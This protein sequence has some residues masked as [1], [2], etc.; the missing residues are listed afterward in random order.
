MLRTA[1]LLLVVLSLLPA[2]AG[3]SELLSIQRE[4]ELPSPLDTSRTDEVS[5]VH[6]FSRGS[7][8]AYDLT[9]DVGMETPASPFLLRS[10]R[11]QVPFRI[12]VVALTEN[13]HGQVA[14][15]FGQPNIRLPRGVRY[16]EGERLR[17]GFQGL[18]VTRVL[19]PTGE[20]METS[21]SGNPRRIPFSPSQVAADFS[22][23][24]VPALPAEPVR[25]G[26]SWVQEYPLTISHQDS[27]INAA[28]VA[29][30]EVIGFS[31]VGGREALIAS[32][33]YSFRTSGVI[34]QDDGS[35]RDLS[36]TLRGQGT[37]WLALETSSSRVLR[38]EF[39]AGIA[40]MLNQAGTSR[41]E[42]VIALS[43]TASMR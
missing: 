4:I 30:Y 23:L 10:Y 41:G 3:A 29:R 1:L 20:V 40:M 37:G 32:V 17:S 9:V 31:M 13:Q 36:T 2:T 39:E 11:L 5:L 7:A 21:V 27:D 18:R 28:V 16:D 12:E 24:V 33:D 35:D 14:W 25:L 34:Q 26:D 42:I 19:T 6:G 15:T 22:S 8:Q 38:H 43:G